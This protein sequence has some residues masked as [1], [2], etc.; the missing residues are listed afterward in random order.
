MTSHARHLMDLLILR[1]R[2]KLTRPY[3]DIGFTPR[4]LGKIKIDE[5]RRA[6]LI[7]TERRQQAT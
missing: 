4:D 3:R 5:A 6:S 7:R 1:L 2:A